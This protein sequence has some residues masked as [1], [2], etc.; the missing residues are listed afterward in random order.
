MKRL[1]RT[2]LWK[3]SF[4]CKVEV[5]KRHLFYYSTLFSQSWF[6][7]LNLTRMGYLP[8]K[9]ISEVHLISTFKE[10]ALQIPMAMAF[11][12]T[13]DHGGQF[14]FCCPKSQKQCINEINSKTAEPKTESSLPFHTVCLLCQVRT[15]EVLQYSEGMTLK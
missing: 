2:V 12:R 11:R 15:S 1:I 7:P 9:G 6:Y 14:L 4:K 5:G 10:A 3:S 13:N 8:Q